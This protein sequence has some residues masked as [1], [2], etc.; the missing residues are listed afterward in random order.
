MLVIGGALANLGFTF[1]VQHGKMFDSCAP[2][3]HDIDVNSGV[4]VCSHTGNRICLENINRLAGEVWVVGEQRGCG[5]HV[6]RVHDGV[7]VGGV[8][9]FRHADSV[10]PC[11]L[12]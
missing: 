6:F 2:V 9:G 4:G 12:E 5:I 10:S 1:E 3:D 7:T 11:T 8:F